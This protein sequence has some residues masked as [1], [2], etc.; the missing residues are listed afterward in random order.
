[1]LDLILSQDGSGYRLVRQDTEYE[2]V[3]LIIKVLTKITF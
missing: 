2:V 3:V 1:M